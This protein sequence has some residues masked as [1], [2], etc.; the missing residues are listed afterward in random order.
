M[1]SD[2]AKGDSLKIYHTLKINI[3]Y[4]KKKNYLKFKLRV[5]VSLLD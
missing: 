5:H 1:K 2:C 4:L 3:Y